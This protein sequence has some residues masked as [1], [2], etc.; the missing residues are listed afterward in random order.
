MS[1]SSRIKVSKDKTASGTIRLQFIDMTTST[2]VADVT[3]DIV[4][5]KGLLEILTKK[6]EEIESV[7]KSKEPDKEIKKVQ[8][9]QIPMRAT[10]TEDSTYTG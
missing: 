2:I 7:I 10:D 8:R 4:T 1:I 6:I 9:Q 5:S 3:L